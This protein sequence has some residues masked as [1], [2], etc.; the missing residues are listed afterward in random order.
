MSQIPERVENSLETL[1]PTWRLVPY[2]NQ[3]EEGKV[4]CLLCQRRCLLA[5]GQSGYC[6]TKVNFHDQ[7]YSTIYGVVAAIGVDPIEKKPIYHYRPGTKILTLGSLG[8]NFRCDF[9]QNWDVAFA[10]GRNSGGLQQPNM[11]PEQA[12]S[13]A[14]ESGCQGISWS[15]NEPSI[16]LEYVLDCAVLA[17]KHG[18]YTVYVTNGYITSEALD[19]L[20]PYLD[21]YRVDV[22]SFSDR[23][24]GKLA[25]GARV[26]PVLESAINARHRWNL[27]VEVVTNVMPGWNDSEQNLNEL[28]AWIVRCL[29]PE[30]PWHLTKF[31]PYAKM[32]DTPPTPVSSIERARD[33]GQANGL[34][35]IYSDGS[36]LG[37]TQATYCPR[38]GLQL[39]SR[40]AYQAQ[41]V[42]GFEEGR[43]PSCSMVLPVVM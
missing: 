32:L 25:H 3:K 33:I 31:V 2:C 38:C 7:L 16:W 20:G 9:C 11:L 42:S 8:C 39:I 26:G 15:Y 21:V 30:T 29:G 13:L 34:T 37:S 24:Y 17:R 41:I 5:P 28:S 18:L 12:V 35:F 4:R 23:F 36:V 22:K 19:V 40:R 27:H 43:C 6:H 10:D 14:I 1:P